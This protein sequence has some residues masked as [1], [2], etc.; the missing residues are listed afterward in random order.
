MM[1]SIYTATSGLQS[2]SKGLDVVSSNVTNVNTVGYKAT[3]LQ[4]NDIHYSFSMRDERQGVIYA[5]QVG[6]GVAA[7]VTSMLFT[8]GDTRQT[9]NDLDVAINGRGFF[10]I[11]GKD[12][13]VYSRDGEFEF[14]DK[15]D[16]VTR[17]GGDRVMAL[18]DGKLQ[19]L[20]RNDYLVQ[21]PAA[22]TEVAFSG[23]LPPGTSTAS[24][25]TSNVPVY[26]SL[27]KLHN[28]TLTFNQDST[29][30]TARAWLVTVTDE[31]GAAVGTSGVLRFQV[32]GSPDVGANAF[33]FT[34][35]PTGAESQQVTLKFGDPNSYSGVTAFSGTAN[36]TVG[37]HDG[38]PEG[39]ML[40]ASF[41]D[42]G[43]LTVRYSNQQ[44]ATGPQLAL[45]DFQDL[46]ALQQLGNGLFRPQKEQRVLLGAAGKDGLG[47]LMAGN[48][49]SSNVD[50]ST[51]FSDMI[52]IQ[53]GYQ[54]SSQVLTT[55]NEMLQQLLEMNHQ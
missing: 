1:D 41:D 26:D 38:R 14:N 34:F 52:I 27:G 55:A 51:Q 10:V 4:Y 30:P 11:E 5:S 48:V 2:F 19:P 40:S 37:T 20:N 53:R 54:A 32:N 45:A 12:G 47:S 31:N 44:T 17:D 13:W 28:L 3:T 46:Q 33:T 49:E 16:L 18:V 29:D 42:Q 25:T 39:T 35:A 50:L 6:G 43:R 22:T 15:G 7:G 23:T 9:G 8:Q 21:K 36:V 24:V